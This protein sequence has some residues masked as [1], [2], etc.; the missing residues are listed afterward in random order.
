MPST[1]GSKNPARCFSVASAHTFL[2]S[3]LKLLSTAAVLP[4]CPLRTVQAPLGPIITKTQ[5]PFKFHQNWTSGAALVAFQ[6]FKF[7]LLIIA[8][9][10]GQSVLFFSV[11]ERSASSPKDSTNLAPLCLIHY[12]WVKIWTFNYSA[13]I[14]PVRVICKDGCVSVT[15]FGEVR[16]EVYEFSL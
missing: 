9:Q 14:R 1:H 5:P 12:V 13:L 10:S 11:P 4:T 7:W 2:P 15:S 6:S 3:D 8:S 16:H